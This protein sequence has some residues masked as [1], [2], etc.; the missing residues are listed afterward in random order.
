MSYIELN[1]ID[2]DGKNSPSDVI[3]RR[4]TSPNKDYAGKSTMI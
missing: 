1:E 4:K 3:I 2:S